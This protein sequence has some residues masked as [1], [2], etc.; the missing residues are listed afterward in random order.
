MPKT[1]MGKRQPKSSENVAAL[2]C[3]AMYLRG[4]TAESMAPRIGVCAET[5]RSRFRKPDT[6]K[7]GEVFA[8]C[9]VLGVPLEKLHDAIKY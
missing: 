5:L 7:L 2:I 6:L 3:G 1:N 4:E 9:K 8:L